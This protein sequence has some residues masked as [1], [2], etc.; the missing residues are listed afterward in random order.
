M[1][2]DLV[3][4]DQATFEEYRKSIQT[5]WNFYEGLD[6]GRTHGM[7]CLH[8]GQNMVADWRW[9]LEDG[10]RVWTWRIPKTAKAAQAE[11]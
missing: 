3:E 8:I 1:S 7:G 10:K 4:V 5:S 9:V 11:S 2:V 6:V